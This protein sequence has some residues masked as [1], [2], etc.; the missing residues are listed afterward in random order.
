MPKQDKSHDPKNQKLIIERV[1]TG[2]R[3]EKRMVKVLKALAEYHDISLGDLLEGIVLHA[4]EGKAP[5]GEESLQRIA[6]LKEIYE[7]DYGVEAS[8][9]FTEAE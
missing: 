9:R 1:Q 2:A 4:F 6:K 3:M 8:H 7:M 5:F